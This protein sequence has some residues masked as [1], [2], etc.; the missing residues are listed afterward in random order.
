MLELSLVKKQYG[1]DADYMIERPSLTMCMMELDLHLVGLETG[2]FVSNR[3]VY[4][5]RWSGSQSTSFNYRG[6][7]FKISGTEESIKIK[8]LFNSYPDEILNDIAGVLG[9]NSDM[10]ITVCGH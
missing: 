5:D 7:T 3:H 8:K 9:F 4:G 6:C 2:G 10:Q 1:E